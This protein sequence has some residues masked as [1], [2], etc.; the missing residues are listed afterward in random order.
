MFDID[1]RL[2]E[3]KRPCGRVYQQ[4]LNQCAVAIDWEPTAPILGCNVLTEGQ[5]TFHPIEGKVVCFPQALRR[6]R[7]SSTIAVRTTQRPDLLELFELAVEMEA[8][9]RS[10]FEATR[11]CRHPSVVRRDLS[12]AD[13][14]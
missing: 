7:G 11:R 12:A 9:L 4:R 8:K 2:V 5:A 14:R 6:R 1:T 3:V 13:R 10:E